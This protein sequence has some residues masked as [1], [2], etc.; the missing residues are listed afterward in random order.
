MHLAA[1]T[2]CKQLP[3]VVED[4]LIEV[5]YYLDKSS[6]RHQGLKQFQ[7]LCRVETCKILK[8]V[9]N[10]WLSLRKFNTR[11]LEQ[12]EHLHEYFKAEITHKRP[13]TKTGVKSQQTQSRG[14][15]KQKEKQRKG[16]ASQSSPEQTNSESTSKDSLS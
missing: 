3:V 8:Y 2:A 13:K 5:S 4:V 7:S 14:S 15:G 9:S 10:Y 12:W 6:N 11:L 1:E 16:N